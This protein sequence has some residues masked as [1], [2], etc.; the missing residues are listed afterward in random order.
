[1]TPAISAKAHTVHSMT[2]VGGGRATYGRTGPG[3]SHRRI[4]SR[5]LN[6]RTISDSPPIDRNPVPN[7]A[8]ASS[9]QQVRRSRHGRSTRCR[10]MTSVQVAV[11]R[12]RPPSTGCPADLPMDKDFAKTTQ[13]EK[14]RRKLTQLPEGAWEII[15]AEKC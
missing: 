6:S 13:A 5:Y 2:R 12:A 3:G 1:M 9:A 15:T 4:A 11:R 14:S 8:P 10:R 7:L